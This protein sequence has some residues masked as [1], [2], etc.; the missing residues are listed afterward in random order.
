MHHNSFIDRYAAA[1]LSRQHLRPT[2]RTPWVVA[3][4]EAVDWIAGLEFGVVSS[5]GMQTWEMVTA[6]AV[7]RKLPLQL[8][9]PVRSAAEFDTTCD[10]IRHQ[11]NLRR[12]PVSFVPVSLSEESGGGHTRTANRRLMI[13]RDRLVVDAADLLVPISIRPRGSMARLINAAAD[14]GTVVERRFLIDPPPRADSFQVNVDQKRLN[15]EL[16]TLADRYLIHWTRATNQP[17]P[18]ERWVDFYGDIIEA[19]RWPRSGLATLKRILKTGRLIAST[20]NMPD[21][22]P[23]VSFSGLPPRDVVPLMTWRAR[24]NRMSFEPYGIAIDCRAAKSIDIQPVAYYDPKKSEKPGAADRWLSQSVG[25]KTDW[26]AE[27]EY[28]YRGDVLLK[29]FDPEQIVIV[30]H[31]PSECAGLRRRFPYRVVSVGQAG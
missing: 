31:R 18:D 17:W 7:R 30:C 4:A 25:R 15:P 29:W 8:I 16:D 23:T 19:D 12:Y 27:R 6:L 22:T 10:E 3:T 13:T 14:D 5:V 26:R 2:G 21:C 24:Y 11:F 28:R 1:L 20:E 9:V